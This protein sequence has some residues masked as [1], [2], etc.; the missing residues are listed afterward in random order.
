MELCHL[1]LDNQIMCLQKI[2][3]CSLNMLIRRIYSLEK[4]L[5][6]AVQYNK[7]NIV[8]SEDFLLQCEIDHLSASI[9]KNQEKF[10]VFWYGLDNGCKQPTY[11]W[12]SEHHLTLTQL[13]LRC[14]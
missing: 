6:A 12:S 4:S 3:W 1:Y 13:N 14:G 9:Q 10:N 2:R 7:F 11:S 5:S 8:S